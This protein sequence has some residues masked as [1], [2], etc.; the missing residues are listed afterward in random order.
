M[1]RR[2][3]GTPWLSAL[4]V[5]IAMLCQATQ[6][7]AETVPDRFQAGI[8]AFAAGRFEEA[9]QAFRDLAGKYQMVS[10]DVQV[11]LGAAEF[12]SGRPGPAIAAFHRAIHLG[13]GTQAAETA[14]VNLARVRTV[15]SQQAGRSTVGP[16]FVFGSYADA[17]TTLAGWA[18][19]RPALAVFLVAWT[20][21]FAALGTWRL[22]TPSRIHA[23]LATVAAVLGIVTVLAGTVAWGSA[24]VQS[25]QVGVVIHND[26]GLL[27]D[28]AATE[29]TLSLP[30]GLEVRVLSSRGGWHEVRLSSG[31]LGWL[32]D[33]ALEVP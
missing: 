12:E 19:P 17:W 25:Y 32:P 9:A 24:R 4:V 26:V 2:A 15:L 13:P 22:T 28:V 31:R 30:E 7:G 23:V 20:L 11:N 27:D 14:A 29:P 5:W 16:A 10:P 8:S 6:A 33:R 18:G 21:F 3:A 1:N